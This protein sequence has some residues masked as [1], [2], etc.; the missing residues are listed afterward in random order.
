[1]L[2]HAA[3]LPAWFYLALPQIGCLLCLGLVAWLSHERL[4]D[5]L[6]TWL[7]TALFAALP[8]FFVS[9]GWL[10]Y[11][12]SWLVLSILLASFI[13]SR[14]VLLAT[15]VLAPWIDERFVI[16]LPVIVTV[17]TLEMP[18]SAVRSV[19]KDVLV[20]AVACVPYV[21]LRLL[22]WLTGEK[23][24][25]RYVESHLDEMRRVTFGTYAFGLWSG[26]RAAWPLV[27]IAIA[28]AWR[29]RGHWLGALLAAVTV[30][31][32]LV[33]LVVASDMSRTLMVL[34]PV[35]LLGAWSLPSL[36][37]RYGRLALAAVLTANLLLPAAHVVW[38]RTFPVHSLP[39]EIANFR[40]PPGWIFAPE[41]FRRGNQLLSEGRAEEAR[42]EYSEA[43]RLENRW[44]APHIQR[45]RPASG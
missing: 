37:K 19:R 9:T 38:T 18:A 44:I 31:T 33:G 25:T 12:D 6:A 17:R 20:V 2:A 41:Y 27:A 28:D 4:H 30:P 24:S 14:A 26:F 21:G 16:A 42:R 5:W 1:M 8:W 43:I 40:D 39:T 34:V 32:A 7:I 11:F 10:A 45:A 29:K 15:C 23:E 35:V 13:P 36:T 22:D 3:H